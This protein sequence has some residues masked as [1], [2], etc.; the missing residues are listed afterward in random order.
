MEQHVEQV[1]AA[2]HPSLRRQHQQHPSL[3]ATACTGTAPHT[4]QHIP[5]V[6]CPSTSQPVLPKAARQCGLMRQRP[7][8]RAAA[9]ISVRPGLRHAASPRAPLTDC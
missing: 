5:A 2:P 9:Q 7:P 6:L 1:A 4:L 8:S 3:A